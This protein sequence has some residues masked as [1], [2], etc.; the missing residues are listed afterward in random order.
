MWNFGSHDM[1]NGLERFVSSQLIFDNV[2]NPSLWTMLK[3]FSD[4]FPD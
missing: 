4:F 3:S 1:F 2:Y